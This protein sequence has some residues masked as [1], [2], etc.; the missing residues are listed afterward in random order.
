V[1]YEPKKRFAFQRRAGSSR[2][3]PLSVSIYPQHERILEQCELEFNVSRSVLLGLWLELEQRDGMIR[4][5][6]VRRLR[7]NNWTNQIQEAA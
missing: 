3:R 7:C 6:M 4:K 5:E 1:S 2:A